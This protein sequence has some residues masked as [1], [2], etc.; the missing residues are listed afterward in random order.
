M[1]IRAHR[2]AA[3][4]LVAAA[5]VL[6]AAG[7]AVRHPTVDELRTAP[8]TTLVYPGATL[9]VRADTPGEFGVDGGNPA[10]LKVLACAGAPASQVIAWFDQALTARGW[11]RLPGHMILSDEATDGVD[12]SLGARRFNLT[13]LNAA[14]T[15]RLAAGTG[16]PTGCA[17]GYQSVAQ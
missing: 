7:C 15:D 10:A 1:S 12:W 6:A 16:H 11:T 9:Y 5:L 17:G 13:L 8:G 2:R 3:P 14:Y 4:V